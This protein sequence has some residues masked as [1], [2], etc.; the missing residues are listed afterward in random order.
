MF[1]AILVARLFAHGSQCRHLQWLARTRYACFITENSTLALAPHS[2]H[3][4][5]C[6]QL[7]PLALIACLIL[8]LLADH[9]LCR[10]ITSTSLA[11]G[12]HH[13][14]LHF[15]SHAFCLLICRC[16]SCQ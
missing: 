8:F 2:S 3:R 9:P 6:I 16:F 14:A 15:L 13:S 10:K 1:V 4:P 12:M 5:S 7:A 11:F